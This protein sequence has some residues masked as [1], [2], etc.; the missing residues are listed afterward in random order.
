[1]ISP[2][3][4]ITLR[5]MILINRN[6]LRTA[7]TKCPPTNTIT[8]PSMTNHGNWS[9]KKSESISTLIFRMIFIY[10]N[11]SWLVILKCKPNWE[12]I[13]PAISMISIKS[14]VVPSS[15]PTFI[16]RVILVDNFGFAHKNSII[17]FYSS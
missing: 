17:H 7:I 16:F 13:T 2:A 8:C 12:V 4:S 3:I 9:K 5:K 14:E 11:Q 10:R 15:V 1:M 6:K